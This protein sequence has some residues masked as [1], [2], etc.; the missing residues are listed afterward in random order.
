MTRILTHLAPEPAHTPILRTPD[1]MVAPLA[2]AS[3]R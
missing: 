1:S 3:L 2:R